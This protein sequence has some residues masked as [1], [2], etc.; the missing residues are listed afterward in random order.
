MEIIRNYLDTMFAN[1]P[2]TPSVLRA[3]DELWQMME[4]KYTELISEG[5]T[6]NEAVG[7]VISEFGNLSELAEALGLEKEIEQQKNPVNGNEQSVRLIGA[8]EAKAFVKAKTEAAFNL[9]LGIAF[10]IFCPIPAIIA[11]GLLP[12]SLEACGVLFL[13]AFI[14]AGVILIV[15]GASKMK[16]W[17]FVGKKG[18]E[19]SMDATKF[20]CAEKD[21]FIKN[22]KMYMTIGILLCAF[23]WI[24]AMIIEEIVRFPR[25]DWLSGV[26]I[27]V[28]I[29]LGVMLIVYSNQI[30]DGYG[31]LLKTIGTDTIK[32]NYEPKKEAEPHYVSFAAECFMS[33]FW[34]TIV[35]AYLII[36]FV[37]GAWAFTWIIWP[38]AAI[39]HAILDKVMRA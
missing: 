6:E 14:A 27:F 12:S 18:V 7:T 8:D 3:R 30:M 36:S 34:P 39:V 13:F 4:D 37:S 15:S 21:V 10:C 5:K 29:G 23:C 33:V 31:L 22:R 35:C 28:C 32:A 17:K 1:L 25:F 2:N 24:P 11:D 9:S 26:F 19:P 38:I 20:A 16:P